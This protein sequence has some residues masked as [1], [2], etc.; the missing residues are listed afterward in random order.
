[1]RA[2]AWIIVEVYGLGY[3][4]TTVD[5]CVLGLLYTYKCTLTRLRLGL[6]HSLVI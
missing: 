2:R 3:I 6:G 1:M 4:I 5:L